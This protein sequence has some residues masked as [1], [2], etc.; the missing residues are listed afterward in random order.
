MWID[1]IKLTYVPDPKEV[2]V[3][4]LNYLPGHS[5]VVATGVARDFPVLLKNNT[6]SAVT[7][8]LSASAQ[9]TLN[10]VL[11]DPGT[12]NPLADSI[13]LAANESRTVTL[14]VNPDSSQSRYV[15]LSFV[16]NDQFQSDTTS[17]NRS[18]SEAN[19]ER[20]WQTEKGPWDGNMYCDHVH[21][22]TGTPPTN[23][24]PEALG[25]VTCLVKS[26]ET[27]SAT[28]SGLDPEN[29][30]LTYNVARQPTKGAL[31]VQSNTGTFTYAPQAGFSGYDFFWFTV[32][33]G[34][35]TSA[36]RVLWL[37]LGERTG[38][39][40]SPGDSGDTLAPAAPANLR[41]H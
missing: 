15:G 38:C 40:L 14:Q 19:L 36:E 23:Q 27:L 16:P 21:V 31:N 35:S 1:D 7:G 6:S 34:S 9:W 25:G 29:A 30:A 28:L 39:N 3:D 41:T 37:T 22:A 11:L 12:G 33:D 17:V 2:S 5:V 20:R 18:F 24:A 8:R 13:T 32:S 10:P 4:I 26:G